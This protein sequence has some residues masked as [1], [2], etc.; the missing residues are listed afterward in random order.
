LPEAQTRLELLCRS[1][2]HR[3]HDAA[4]PAP[5]GPEND[6]QRQI[7]RAGVAVEMRGIEIDRVSGKKRLMALTASAA[8]PTPLGWNAIERMATRTWNR[9]RICHRRS[10]PKESQG[11]RPVRASM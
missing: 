3:S 10:Y 4:R 9:D 7:R 8:F 6:E 5:S 2:K 1:F 11:G